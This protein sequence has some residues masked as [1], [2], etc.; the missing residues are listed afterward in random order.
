L[1]VRAG[2]LACGLILAA[3]V[4]AS[5][6]TTNAVASEAALRALAATNDIASCAKTAHATPLAYARRLNSW[7]VTL[8]G[9]T[10]ISVFEGGCED[11]NDNDALYVFAARASQPYKL[12]SRDFGFLEKLTPDGILG[13]M[14]N[15][16]GVS[17]RY[18][19]T[20]RWNGSTF[21]P[22]SSTMVW[23]STR[24]SKP[25][26][27]PLAFAPGTSS[28]TVSGTVR[29]D[30]PDVYEFD[31]R[32]G[33]RLSVD[34]RPRRGSACRLAIAV[35]DGAQIARGSALSWHGTLPEAL[36]TVILADDRADSVPG[37]HYAITMTVSIR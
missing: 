25:A 26:H 2:T 15:P 24:E 7:N 27:R 3:S 10:S 30:F 8:A 12:V 9:G 19:D 6:A 23:Q 22:A 20:A 17:V 37:G 13:L 1:S 36:H 34:V 31:A 35:E 21:V 33:Q 32:A 11:G 5:A 28:A 14:H 29:E 4:P 16:G 18:H